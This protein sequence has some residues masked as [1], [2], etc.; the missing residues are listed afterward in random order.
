VTATKKAP[1]WRGGPFWSCDLVQQGAGGDTATRP[2]IRQRWSYS[3]PASC[4]FTSK[5]NSPP[6]PV[7]APSMSL[8]TL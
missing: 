8:S 6:V 4:S 3:S 2:N 1:R 7:M 5:T